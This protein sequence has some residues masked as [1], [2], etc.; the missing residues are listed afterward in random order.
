[1]NTRERWLISITDIPV[2][3]KKFFVC[4]GEHF[5]RNRREAGLARAGF[6]G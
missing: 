1:M 5:Q 2:P 4:L 3:A 6:Y